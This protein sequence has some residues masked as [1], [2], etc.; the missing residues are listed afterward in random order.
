[1]LKAKNLLKYKDLIVVTFNYR[2]GIHGFLCL[3]TENIPGMK[4]QLA[5]LK[6]IQQNI[7]AFGGNPKDVTIAG[8][9]AGSISVDLLTIC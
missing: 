2:L 3:G 9:S 5:L 7:A 4:D 1:M 8:Y 6:W